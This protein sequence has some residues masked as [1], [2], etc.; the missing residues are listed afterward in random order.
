MDFTLKT[1]Q[2]LLHALKRNGYKFQTFEE[3]LSNP[4]NG[5]SVVLRHD[6]D[7]L[8]QN[9]FQLA[10]LEHQ[11]GVQ[12]SYYIRVRKGVWD[13]TII[14]KIVSFGHEISYH[15]ED[16][17]IARGNDE[18]A[19]EHFKKQLAKIREFYPAKTICMHGSPLSKWDNCKLWDKYDYRSMGIIGEP[20]L[21]VDYSKILYITD[22]GRSWNS[23][24]VSVRDKVKDGLKVSI[25]NTT[26][27]ISL[28]DGH[29]LPDKIIMNT[30]PQRWFNFGFGWLREFVIQN[31]KNKVKR[32][33]I[34][35]S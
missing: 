22:T 28:L 17:T 7:K 29:Q 19:L 21:D 4:L 5:K 23:A 27:L 31:I 9:A 30:H 14:K 20:Y 15:Y 32:I 24:K 25:K 1:Y 8:P 26:H 12:A 35:L 3:F 11:N 13:E 34:K 10:Q 18:K 2:S 16:L 33:L 6:I